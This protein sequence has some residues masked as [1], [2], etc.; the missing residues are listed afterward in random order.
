MRKPRGNRGSAPRPIWF[1]R[2]AYDLRRSE[3]VRKTCGQLFAK[4]ANSPFAEARFRAKITGQKLRVHSGR[5]GRGPQLLTG[6]AE[7]EHQASAELAWRA[8]DERMDSEPAL[9][10]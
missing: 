1:N 4:L 6:L 7:W 9:P 5:A 8:G 3:L 10:Q 2:L